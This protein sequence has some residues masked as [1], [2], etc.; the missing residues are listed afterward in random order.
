MMNYKKFGVN[1]TSILNHYF[2]ITKEATNI[3]SEWH[4]YFDTIVMLVHNVQNRSKIYVRLI[5]LKWLFGKTIIR[6]FEDIK[7]ASMWHHENDSSGKPEI[8]FL[9]TSIQ[10]NRMMCEVMNWKIKIW[11][12][13]GYQFDILNVTLDL[14]YFLVSL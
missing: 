12:S 9:D 8:V 2:D 10:Y 5:S 1:T 4:P 14:E 11:I 6:N 7:L 3:M 13:K